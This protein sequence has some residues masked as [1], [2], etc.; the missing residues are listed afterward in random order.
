MNW[1]KLKNQDWF[2]TIL[3]LVLS[4]LGLLVIYSTTYNATTSALG[5]GSLP[6][7]VVFLIFGLICYFFLATLD[8]S[9][10]EN[11]GVLNVLYAIIILL[12][13]YVKFFGVTIAGT[14]RWINIGFFS[15]QPSEYA[16]IIIILITAQ[17]F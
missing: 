14:N 12:L 15:L 3:A 16:K 2:I 8:F 11:R 10:V 1:Q 9:W 17:I 5:A 4:V 13:I 6:K 7:Q